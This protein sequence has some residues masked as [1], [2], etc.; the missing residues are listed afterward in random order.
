M[1][2]LITL[3]AKRTGKPSAGNPHAGFDVAGPGNGAIAWIEAPAIGE[4][5]RKRLLPIT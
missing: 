5:R 4:S 1:I 3:G 2:G